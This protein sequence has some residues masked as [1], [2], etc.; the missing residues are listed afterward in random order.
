M[1]ENEK[2]E[3]D[4]LVNGI[5]LIIKMHDDTPPHGR[6]G[7]PQFQME[8]IQALVKQLEAQEKETNQLKVEIDLLASLR[9]LADASVE[10]L[11]AE[12]QELKGEVE[13]RESSLG[14]FRR[15]EAKQFATIKAL[16]IQNTK[17]QEEYNLF[18]DDALKSSTEQN[19]RE[20]K[21]IKALDLAKQAM[22]ESDLQPQN[23]YIEHRL[24]RISDIEKELD[25]PNWSPVSESK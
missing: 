17:L 2:R 4:H 6:F 19:E 1:T 11:K 8:A 12:V 24:A 21:L 3:F 10:S 15:T 9:S 7:L 22:K 23:A 14:L 5:K 25:L 13:W 18:I 16:A 20:T